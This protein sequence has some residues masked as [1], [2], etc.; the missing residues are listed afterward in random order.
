MS[1]VALTSFVALAILLGHPMVLRAQAG[2]QPEKIRVESADQLPRHTYPVP[3]SATALVEDDAQFAALATKLE[4]DLKADLAKY[5]ISDRATLEEYYGTLGSLALIEGDHEA[6]LA[7]ADSVRAIEDKPGLKALTG[8]FERALA[9]AVQVA[10][11]QRAAVFEE[12][13]R[14]EIAAL[15]Y[16]EVQAELKS[17]KGFTEISARLTSRG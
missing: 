6:A 15:H 9:A 10:E 11:D 4:A 12:T 3:E 16:D 5:E 8:T 7:Y 1:R 17:L 13:Y 2:P 14:R